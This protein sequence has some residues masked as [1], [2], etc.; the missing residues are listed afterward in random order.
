MFRIL[1]VVLVLLS[2]DVFA[3]SVPETGAIQTL[4]DTF[5]NAGQTWPGK[6]RDLT[7]YA[8]FG[9]V[10][11]SWV[12]HFGKKG[13]YGTTLV[14]IIA[15]LFSKSFVVLVSYAVFS[16][17]PYLGE[18]II[19]SI[20]KIG[21][22]L[23]GGNITPSSVFD[24]GL[25]FSYEILKQLNIINW[26][27]NLGYVIC[28][29]IMVA[30][31][32]LITLSMLLCYV[33]MYVFI[34]AGTIVMFLLGSEW[35]RDYAINYFR[36][37]LSIAVKFFMMQL[38]I[39]LSMTLIEGW[40]HSSDQGLV[41]VV[42]LMAVLIVIYGLIVS[43][44]AMAQS[45]ISGIDQT[46]SGT[47]SKVVGTGAGIAALTAAVASGGGST[48]LS[49]MLNG[50]GLLSESWKAASNELNGDGGD[51]GDGGDNPGSD[52]DPL[53]GLGG[54]SIEAGGEQVPM[55]HGGEDSAGESAAGDNL[56]NQS[57]PGE[58]SSVHGSSDENSVAAEGGE[59]SEEGGSS[60]LDATNSPI[61]PRAGKMAVAKLAGKKA[62]AAIMA[63]IKESGKAKLQGNPKGVL[64]RARQSLADTNG[65]DG[66]G[67]G[68]GGGA[69]DGAG[70]GAGVGFAP[71][72]SR[73]TGSG[74][75]ESPWYESKGGAGSLSPRQMSQARENYAE[76]RSRTGWKHSFESYVQYT[77]NQHQV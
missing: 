49:G 20:A 43:I 62:G 23:V 15:D 8:F 31:F 52:G 50:G 3:E 7:L 12:F 51:G 6:I 66:A 42:L 24:L 1:L 48:V 73:G 32:A 27:Q 26:V 70:G 38:I 55:S 57:S 56:S 11:L 28:V 21:G 40:L 29:I 68:A 33:E 9:L 19:K 54:G 14:E 53:S 17:A 63:A 4:Q 72:A 58:T 46:N 18:L 67:G 44:P 16:N 64:G 47:M 2:P 76:W 36:L 13:L 69:G 10:V 65:G 61:A 59:S 35:T 39:V 37:L 60:P 5:K 77:Q 30:I 25:S 41:E 34:N 71:G 45:L 75:G 74:S 22:D